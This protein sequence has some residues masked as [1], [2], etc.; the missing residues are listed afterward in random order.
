MFIVLLTGI[1]YYFNYVH[2]QEEYEKVLAPPSQQLKALHARENWQL[3]HY[4]YADRSKGQVRI[5]IARAMELLVNES[6]AGKLPYST[7]D[8]PVKKAEPPLAPAGN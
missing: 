7:V 8:Q 3:E 6:A 4:S 1:T 2:E 5:P